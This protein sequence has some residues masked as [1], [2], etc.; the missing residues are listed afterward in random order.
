MQEM[1]QRYR[2]YVEPFV[3]VEAND[4]KEA[5]EKF[6]EKI[7]NKEI[8]LTVR[9]VGTD[10]VIQAQKKMENIIKRKEK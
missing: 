10:I 7:R 3:E 6:I 9:D 1:A 8:K 5:V 2:I 4:E